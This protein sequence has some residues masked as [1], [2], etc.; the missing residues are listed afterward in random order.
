[1]LP[2]TP[3]RPVDLGYVHHVADHGQSALATC[4][5]EGRRTAPQLKTHSDRSVNHAASTMPRRLPSACNF[6]VCQGWPP[7]RL[8]TPAIACPFGTTFLWMFYNAWSGISEIRKLLVSNT[9]HL[10]STPLTPCRSYD[11]TLIASV[12]I[13]RDQLELM[14]AFLCCA[15]FVYGCSKSDLV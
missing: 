11:A 1:M 9:R 7:F 4:I 6:H 8:S 14:L 3:D 15:M 10:R 12:T 5:A 13:W 2:V